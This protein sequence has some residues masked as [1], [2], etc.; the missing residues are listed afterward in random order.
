MADSGNCSKNNFTGS[1]SVGGWKGFHIF[2]YS[3]FNK[4]NKFFVPVQNY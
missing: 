3:M 4:K 1:F 2:S